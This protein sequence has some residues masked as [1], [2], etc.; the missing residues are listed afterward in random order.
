MKNSGTSH[1]IG[2]I[3][4]SVLVEYSSGGTAFSAS[5]AACVIRQKLVRHLL[6]KYPEL[7][8][9]KGKEI[10][11]ILPP[12]DLPPVGESAPRWPFLYSSVCLLLAMTA[13]CSLWRGLAL[14][15]SAWAAVPVIALLSILFCVIGNKIRG[16]IVSGRAKQEEPLADRNSREEKKGPHLPK[17]GKLSWQSKGLIAFFVWKNLQ[18]LL[19]LWCV[20]RGN[21]RLALVCGWTFLLSVSLFRDLVLGRPILENFLS[22][23]RIWIEQGDFWPLFSSFYGFWLWL[24]C[25]IAVLYWPRV[26]DFRDA[27]HTVHAAALRWYEACEPL[28]DK[29]AETPPPVKE[30]SLSSD[31][32]RSLHSFAQELPRDKGAWLT[33]RLQELGMDYLKEDT[34]RDSDGGLK[35]SESLRSHYEVLGIVR[36]GDPCFV[37][38]PPETSGGRVIRKGLLRRIR[39]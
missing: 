30:V 7:P 33:E 20:L 35:W 8:A 2:E 25:C 17:I 28:A 1:Y 6:E 16:C 10:S 13:A 31:L 27:A 21:I 3:V 29:L 9:E 38:T 12:L 19:F 11:R 37:D 15:G 39:S 22:G 26:H 18:R 24:A 36:E 34:S 23:M 5:A 14:S 4:N 32:G